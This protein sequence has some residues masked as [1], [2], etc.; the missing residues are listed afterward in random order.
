MDLCGVFCGCE[1]VEGG[2]EVR[3]C[4]WCDVRSS[5]VLVGSG[6]SGGN[7]GGGVV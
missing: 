6:G 1:W 7:G 5:V 3:L 2:S 4:H